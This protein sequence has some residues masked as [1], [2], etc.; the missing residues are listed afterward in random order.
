MAS[1]EVT[2]ELH[3]AQGGGFKDESFVFSAA[4][5]EVYESY[6][7][8]ASTIRR[9][10]RIGNP[11]PAEDDAIIPTAGLIL[12]DNE[13]A[14]DIDFG[15]NNAA[16]DV[17]VN[18]WIAGG[19]ACLCGVQDIDQNTTTIDSGT[20]DPVRGFWTGGDGGSGKTTRIQAVG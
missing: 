10:L 4:G 17:A 3:I 12:I 1:M 11:N 7:D 15:L 16:N 9:V 20:K 18:H 2:V 8:A 5:T 13:D 19:A 6:Q 14:A